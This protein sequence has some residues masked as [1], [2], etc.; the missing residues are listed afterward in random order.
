MV[1][2]PTL[3]VLGGYVYAVMRPA[4]RQLKQIN[5]QIAQ[6]SKSPV[7][8]GAMGE[9]Q[10]ELQRALRML[11]TER[12]RAA[13]LKQRKEGAVTR[14]AS[15]SAAALELVA[16]VVEKRGLVLLGS[17]R[18]SDSEARSLLPPQLRPAADSSG[19]QPAGPAMQVWR[20][21]IEGSYA[22]VL[23]CLEEISAMD[24]LIIP[25]NLTMEPA[26]LQGGGRRWTIWLY[27]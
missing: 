9:Q 19:K 5:A 21:E 20:I 15:N 22:A 23:G 6:V 11:D 16:N 27:V 24:N 10:K 13:I 18:V 26:R 12:D 1:V 17:G 3:A 7:A 25:L 2:L 4:D 8:A 14:P